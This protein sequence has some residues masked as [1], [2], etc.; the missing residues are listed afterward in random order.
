M[1][2]VAVAVAAAVG[3]ALVGLEQRA[4]PSGAATGPARAVAITELPVPSSDDEPAPAG[5]VVLTAP[6]TSLDTSADGLAEL[7][8][9]DGGHVVRLS[10]LHVGDGRGYVV[11][12]VAAGS[13]RTPGGGVFLGPL[14]GLEGAQNYGVPIDARLD[15]PLTVLIWSREFKGPVGHASLRR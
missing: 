12:L 3:A 9:T 6:L 14:K 13:A 11:Y 5:S 7:L 4:H 2:A 10:S 15:G 8:R 1:V